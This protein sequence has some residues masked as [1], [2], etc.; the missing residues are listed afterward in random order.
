MLS[1]ITEKAKEIRLHIEFS[2]FPV[3]IVGVVMIFDDKLIYVRVEL[4][5]RNL[6]I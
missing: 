1:D 5:S 6:N 3:F 4:K 2:R